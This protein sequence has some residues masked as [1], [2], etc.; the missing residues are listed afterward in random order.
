MVI[1]YNPPP[2]V[3]VGLLRIVSTAVKKI[4]VLESD[5]AVVDALANEFAVY[6]CMVEAVDDAEAARQ[7]ATS[8]KFVL[9]AGSTTLAKSHGFLAFTFLKRLSEL[10]G[11][12]F[13]IM[14][15]DTEVDQIASHQNRPTHADVYIQKPFDFN[16]LLVQVSGYLDIEG[17]P[18]AGDG[19]EEIVL[20]DAVVVDD[21]EAPAVDRA[22]VPEIPE[23]ELAVLETPTDDG[24]FEE[25][26]PPPPPPAK[27]KAKGKGKAKAEQPEEPPPKVD[28]VT[29]RA[30]ARAEE[31]VEALEKEI[32]GLREK[33]EDAKARASKAEEEKRSIEGELDTLK[34]K[35]EDLQKALG[36]K[37][38]ASVST[39][40]LLDLRE[41]INRKDK[42]VLNLKDSVNGKEKELLE[43]KDRVVSQMRITADFEDKLKA[44]EMELAGI[45]KTLAAVSKDKE[46]ASKRAED[47]KA[48]WE[49]SKQE[50]ARLQGELEETKAKLIAEGEALKAKAL[51]EQKSQLDAEKDSEIGS[52]KISHERALGE[53][54]DQY[55]AEIAGIR[56]KFEGDLKELEKKDAA[57]KKAALD[58]LKA[59]MEGQAADLAAK[60]K[61]R[62]QEIREQIREKEQ[63]NKAL[64]K[65]TAGQ[66]KQIG[67]LQGRVKELEESCGELT[68]KVKDRT[69]EK[70]K[71]VADLATLGGQAD[72]LRSSLAAEKGKRGE[73]EIFI[74]KTDERITDGVDNMR[75]LV[76]TIDSRDKY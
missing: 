15:N 56:D 42:E 34:S 54:K 41:L 74:R 3:L 12:P 39:R 33:A 16:D 46:A 18:V 10:D 60:A 5:G 29:E 52:L 55:E 73:A 72:E 17:A 26:S 45:E 1:P 6:G 58:A 14:F 32:S 13:V 75:S 25:A 71:L 61:E 64:M 8:D 70:E 49:S 50:V 27:G 31:K 9:V 48:H 40:E 43:E 76:K 51:E 30:L 59:E 53:M 65:E 24:T 28:A 63:I 66:E 2:L 22:S 47:H 57:D 23:D 7:K 21:G 36:E 68:E 37:G 38:S 19:T 44:T 69:A 35:V 11:V 67:E 4:L 62:E 20:D